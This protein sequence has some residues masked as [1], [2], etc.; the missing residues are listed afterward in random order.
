MIR[1]DKIQDVLF[2]G[3]GFRQSPITS[4]A[5]VDSDNQA[6]DSGLFFQDGSPMVTIKNIKDTQQDIE[7]DAAAFNAYLKQLQEATIIESCRKIV[8]GES[9]F[10]QS[11]NLYPYEKS[12]K[13]TIDPLSK[14]VGFEIEP[15]ICS[16]IILRVPWIE[17]S[18]DSAA[19]FDVHLFN[20]NLKDPIETKSVTVVAGESTI[21]DL[22]WFVADDI[23]YKGGKFYLGYFQDDLSGAKAFEKDYEL[24]SLQVSTKY[25]SIEPIEVDQT[26]EVL[27]IT[28]ATKITL[29][30][31]LNLGIETYNDYTELIIRN[32]NLFWDVIQLQM[33]EKCLNIF[34]TS[35]RSNRTDRQTDQFKDLY[36]ELYGDANHGIVGIEGSLK[37]SVEDLRKMLFRKPLISIGTLS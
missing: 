16:K 26:A 27:D 25:Y 29:T 24:S 9:D 12:F 15:Y 30:H 32:K 21:I 3:V 20:S 17:L 35:T 37:R 13:T 7:G 22:G 31:G 23:K 11:A 6:S 8:R 28:T 10:I 18:F 14:F 34:K 4:Y 2:G 36:L 33:A 1:A 19:T 5:V